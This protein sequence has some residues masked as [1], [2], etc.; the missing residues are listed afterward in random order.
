MLSATGTT[1]SCSIFLAFYLAGFSAIPARSAEAELTLLTL[2]GDLIGRIEAL[3]ADIDSEFLIQAYYALLAPEIRQEAE[4]LH[5]GLIDLIPNYEV[6]F[7]AA[8]SAEITEVK[9]DIDVLWAGVRTL[10]SL[11]FTREVAELLNTAYNSAF[12]TLDLKPVN[13]EAE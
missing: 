4:T 11:H 9:F 6:A 7:I 5:T 8:D 12:S 3:E 10:H 2:E 1:L 13:T